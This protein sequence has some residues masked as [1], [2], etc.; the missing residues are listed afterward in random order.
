V[1]LRIPIQTQIESQRIAK[2]VWLDILVIIAAK[3]RKKKKVK[4]REEG[5]NLVGV[6]Y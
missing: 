6:V 2:K 5:M 4:A 1:D 3:C